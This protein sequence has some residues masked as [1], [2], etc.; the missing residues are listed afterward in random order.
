MSTIWTGGNHQDKNGNDFSDIEY[1]N[2]NVFVAFNDE[3]TASDKYS[4]QSAF[5]IPPEMEIENIEHI[6]GGNTFQSMISQVVI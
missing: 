2:I 3:S 1:D 6:V 4:L 5:A